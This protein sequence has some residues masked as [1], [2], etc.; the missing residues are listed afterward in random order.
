MPAPRAMS[1]TLVRA[2]PFSENKRKDVS[3]ICLR[4]R[5]PRRGLRGPSLRRR[6]RFVVTNTLSQACPPKANTRPMTSL[7]EGMNPVNEITRASRSR[8]CSVHGRL[9]GLPPHDERGSHHSHSTHSQS[10][11]ALVSAHA[12]RPEA[13]IPRYCSR[14]ALVSDETPCVGGRAVRGAEAVRPDLHTK[15]PPSLSDGVV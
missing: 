11:G 8:S 6:D 15:L 9:L 12:S 5:G 1:R 7:A 3:R 2:N 14:T 10:V 13:S 4:V